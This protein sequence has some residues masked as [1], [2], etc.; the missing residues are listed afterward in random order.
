M[1]FPTYNEGGSACFKCHGKIKTL[2]A[3]VGR[4]QNNFTSLVM[5]I[6]Y[7]HHIFGRAHR[8]VHMNR[9]WCNTIQVQNYWDTVYKC[10]LI[11]KLNIRHLATHKQKL[12]LLIEKILE[13]ILNLQ[14]GNMQNE[15]I[16]ANQNDDQSN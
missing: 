9:L 7:Q 4:V 11:N 6:I 12:I 14:Y 3:L 16:L 13:T 15:F 1:P 10:K 8:N 5:W 2:I